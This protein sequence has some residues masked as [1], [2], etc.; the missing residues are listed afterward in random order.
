MVNAIMSHIQNTRDIS[1]ESPESKDHHRLYRS[2]DPELLS[3]VNG[4]YESTQPIPAQG[5]C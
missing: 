2:T 3:K 4:L 1:L 5:K